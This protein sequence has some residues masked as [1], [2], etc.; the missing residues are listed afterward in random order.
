MRLVPVPLGFTYRMT[1][2]PKGARNPCRGLLGGADSVGVRHIEPAEASQAFRIKRP[3]V[4]VWPL[5]F[6]RKPRTN[7]WEWVRNAFTFELLFYEGELWWPYMAD[8]YKYGQPFRA[9]SVTDCLEDIRDDHYLFEMP[10]VDGD[11]RVLKEVP[12]IRT[13]I[14]TNHDEK[15][16]QSKRKAYENFLICG[17]RAYVRGGLPVFFRNSHG[18][19][20]T[21]EIDIAN[22]GSD[23]RGNPITHG[24][25]SPPGSFHEAYTERAL[26]SGAFW[27]PNE[28]PAAK[29][30]A[31]PL[32]TK[33]PRIEVLM[34]EL[35]VD[36]RQRIRLDSLFREVVRMFSHPFYNHW[37]S[38]A[39]WSFRKN[40]ARLCDP[41]LDD[42]ELSRLRLGLLRAF[43][44]KI[45]EVDFWD[46]DRIR[47]DIISFDIQ[48]RFK[49]TWPELLAADDINAL[50]SLVQ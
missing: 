15:L 23:R 47:R 49:P 10:T 48:E 40:F 33:F 26:G 35:V 27:L 32:Q 31:H 24:L 1:Y 14:E 41:A 5:V 38:R 6:P 4:D 50:S 16:A 21:W 45:D 13:L 7:T 20:I 9:Y 37:S 18:N 17:N 44:A 39:V 36:V 30:A 29:S 11:N 22:V 8:D 19:K 12:A 43:A 42:L 46:M 34:P 25:Y 2:V 3:K 28:F